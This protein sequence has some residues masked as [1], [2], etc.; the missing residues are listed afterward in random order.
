MQQGP[1][2]RRLERELLE[3]M[4]ERELSS[5]VGKTHC[6]GWNPSR[7]GEREAICVIIS[8][9]SKKIVDNDCWCENESS[10]LGWKERKAIKGCIYSPSILL[11]GAI[12]E[13]TGKNTVST[14]ISN[15]HWN[16]F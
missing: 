3:F 12:R 8:N 15:S 16:H 13:R 10:K 4:S 5:E 6:R 7:N 1:S 9:V 2:G 14:S 11:T